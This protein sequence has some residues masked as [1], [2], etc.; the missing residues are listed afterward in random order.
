MIER[1]VVASMRN[2]LTELRQLEVRI[3]YSRE[4]KIIREICTYIMAKDVL[5]KLVYNKNYAKG[6]RFTLPCALKSFIIKLG[7]K[8]LE[9]STEEIVDD[10]LH[11]LINKKFNLNI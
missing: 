11:T 5:I 9:N 4:K 8:V 10:F 3:G 7:K 6:D 1:E 2:F